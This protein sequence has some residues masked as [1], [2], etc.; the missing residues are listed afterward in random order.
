MVQ[1]VKCMYIIYCAKETL[2]QWSRCYI[3]I[4]LLTE[5]EDGLNTVLYEFTETVLQY[6]GAWYKIRTQTEMV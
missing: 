6:T 4:A 2:L 3:Q 5:Y 1:K